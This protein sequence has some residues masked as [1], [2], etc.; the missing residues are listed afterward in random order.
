[1]SKVTFVPADLQIMFFFHDDCCLRKKLVEGKGFC[2]GKTFSYFFQI[3][4][5]Q[6]YRGLICRLDG[7]DGAI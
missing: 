7:T 6:K 2:L 5:I 1:M 3:L 4:F